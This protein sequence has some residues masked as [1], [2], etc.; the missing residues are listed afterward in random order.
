MIG[1]ARLVNGWGPLQVDDNSVPMVAYLDLRGSYKWDDNLQLYA[2]V[3]NLTDVPP[4]IIPTTQAGGQS[5]YYFPQ[6]RQD[7]Y[8]AIGRQ[9]RV[10]IRFNY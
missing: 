6:I 5:A 9:Y 8:D 10:G 4:P 2:A 1:S 3:D 7:I